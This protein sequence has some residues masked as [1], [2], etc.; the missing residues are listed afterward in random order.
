MLSAAILGGLWLV[1]DMVVKDLL[2]LVFEP[3]VSPVEVLSY[4]G[5]TIEEAIADLTM[6]NLPYAEPEYEYNDTEEQGKVI[7]Q[8]PAPGISILPGGMT[9][10][11]LVVSNGLEEVVIPEDIKFG[12]YLDVE[13]KLRDELK[14][15]P[16][17]VAEYSD[18]VAQG[19]VISTD[20]PMG[21]TVR[22]GS[23]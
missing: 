15:K 1:Y 11:E 23:E 9:K 5:M 2:A 19:R 4:K 3:K 7:S 16:R 17:E 10:V 21:S 13:L 8:K 22:V 12:D 18:E 14:L 20:P 6:K